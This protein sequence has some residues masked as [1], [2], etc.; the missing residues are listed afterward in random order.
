MITV[1]STWR[2][3]H[4]IDP[5]VGQAEMVYD[6]FEPFAVLL[7]FTEGTSGVE[8]TLDRALMITAL[9]T[10]TRPVGIGDSRFSSDSRWYLIRILTN[11]VTCDGLSDVTV[12]L[13]VVDV[14]LFLSRT[15]SAVPFGQEQLNWTAID[16]EY[17][18]L[19]ENGV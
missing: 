13:P 1:Q 17:R 5:Y 11:D 15:I 2:R 10:L 8:W 4:P 7:R 16:D 9:G 19:T 3:V 12:A 14:A 18:S 6:P